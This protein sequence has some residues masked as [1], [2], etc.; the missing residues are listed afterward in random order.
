MANKKCS[1]PTS[2]ASA[3]QVAMILLGILITPVLLASSSLGSQLPFSKMLFAIIVGSSILTLLAI[4]NM[5]IGVKAR[6][7]TYGIIKFTFG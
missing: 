1:N 3:I 7:P 6:L 5:S 4:I 2:Y